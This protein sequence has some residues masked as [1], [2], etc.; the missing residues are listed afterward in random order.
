MD[1]SRPPVFPPISRSFAPSDTPEVEDIIRLTD[2]RLTLPSPAGPVQI[3][4]GVS[5]RVGRGESVSLVGPSGSGKTTT[6][7]LMAGLE[8][9]SSGDVIVAGR[10]LNDLDEDALARLRRGRVGVVFQAFHLAPTMTALENAA[11]PLELAGARDADERARA[12]LAAVGLNHR[13]THY[14]SQLSGG[15]QQ[16]VALAR[17]FAVG[18]DLLLADE[19]TGNLD[20]ESGIMVMDLL[21]SLRDRAGTT[22]VLITHDAELTAR[23][24]RVLHMRDGQILET[25]GQD[26]A[27]ETPR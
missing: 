22:L 17:A 25:A 11:L 20:A 10:R 19:P 16:R 15:E 24:G 1:A 5:M 3:L 12:A 27:P 7:M 26:G 6:L 4:R 2:V 14:P 23:C 13:L 18:P 8:R 9:P 21:F